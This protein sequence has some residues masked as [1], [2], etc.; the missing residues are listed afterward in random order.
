MCTFY[1][2]REM[3]CEIKFLG[4][5][6]S[7]LRIPTRILCRCRGC[8]CCSVTEQSESWL[9][10]RVEGPAIYSGK[11]VSVIAAASG[12]LGFVKMLIYFAGSHVKSDLYSAD[13]RAVRF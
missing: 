5:N 9:M 13:S 2:E 1:V 7:A 6:H 11:D 3:D 4:S 12:F 10:Q 8:D